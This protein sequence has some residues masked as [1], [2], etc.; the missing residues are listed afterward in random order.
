MATIKQIA[1]LA[2]VSIGTVSDV[3]TGSVPVSEELR[4]RVENA[5]RKLNYFPNHVARSLKTSRTRTLGI[6]VPD[7]T[8]PFF[9]RVIRGAEAA[10]LEHNHSLIA[11]NSDD[12]V[13]R[14]KKLLA[15]LRSQRVDG[16][17]LVV[18]AGA[19]SAVEIS[20]IKNSG[21]TLV[22]LDR[23]PE[24]LEVD[25]V[26]VDNA[27]AADLGVSH[28]ISRG[29]RK[30]AIATGLLT[31]RNEQ[32]RLQ[33][34]KRA[35]LRAGIKPEPGWIWEG[36]FRPDHVAGICRE[37]L[38]DFRE[39]PAAIFATNGP[40]GLGVLRG[41][42][43]SHLKTPADI[44]FVTFDELT[45]DDL[46]TPSVT[47]VVQ[48]AYDIGFRA[49]EILIRRIE[50]GF[51]GPANTVR[52]PARVEIRESSRFVRSHVPGSRPRKR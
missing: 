32:E 45:V 14:E 24:G 28:L 1:E 42:R 25:S 8:I 13:V 11:V 5:I 38:H 35:L 41:L 51:R 50:H 17:L 20:E 26:S 9:P 37:R 27:A 40:T 7:L 39:R 18:A 33:G 31:L 46:F 15:L 6:M 4:L 36:D 21:V 49:A 3:I 44:G 2:D 30:I 29:Y 48:P 47:A 19:S 43:D 16:I 34:Y 12:N 23:I 22:Y 52:L 10:A